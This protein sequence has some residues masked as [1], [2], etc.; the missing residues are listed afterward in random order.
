MNTYAD[1][2]VFEGL[3]S[4]DSLG[5]VNSQHLVDQVL[6][7]WSHCVPLWGWKLRKTVQQVTV[8]VG[9]E[10]SNLLKQS[11]NSMISTRLVRSLLLHVAG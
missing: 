3:L 11:E 5:W 4:S 10:H 9:K 7:L 2:W 1:P 6:C 8:T